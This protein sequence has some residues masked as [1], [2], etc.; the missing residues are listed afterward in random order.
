MIADAALILIDGAYGEGGG[1]TVRTALAMASL[2]QQ[3]VRMFNVRGGTK[4]AGL[5]PE[6]LVILRTLA[7]AST[8]TVTDDVVG[9]HS[10]T[11]SPT[12]RARSFNG[13]IPAIRNS[14]GRGP[15][16]LVVLNAL[17]PVLARTGAYSELTVDGET[18]GM[19]AL[20]YDAFANVTLPVLRNLGIHAFAEQTRAGFG[21]ES[22]GEVRLEIEPSAVV[23]IKW[24]DRGRL[25]GVHAILST[26]GVAA[27]LIDRAKS[28]LKKLAQNVSVSLNFEHIEV[29]SPI[30]GAYL[31]LWAEYDKGLGSATGMAMKGMRIESLMQ[32]TFEEL[33][34]W[35]SGPAT[36]DPYLA[37]QILIPAVLAEGE[38]TFK[39]S[40]LTSR[41]LTTAWVIK[42]FL[43][44]HITIRGSE[45]T[46]G[47]VS[48]HR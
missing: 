7:E 32:A 34:D 22:A 4:Y 29:G 27:A 3:P 36:V 43:P 48:V 37:D 5:D 15:N 14:G 20:S 38:S 31:T 18:F 2:T 26:S 6:D 39:V 45:G 13:I 10:F 30:P 21:R 23:P 44:V 12:R 19:N 11:F 33:L 40:R 17:L 47:T 42:Q 25:N 41:F 16:A 46:A 28:H 1:A 8:A 35:M 9:A 24:S